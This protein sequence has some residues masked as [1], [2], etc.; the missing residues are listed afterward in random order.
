M[1]ETGGQINKLNRFV[2][3]NNDFIRSYLAGLKLVELDSA[4]R[5]LI[6]KDL[7]NLRNLIRVLC[8][9]HQLI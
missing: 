4:G 7:L 2:K 8:S 6:P 5:I 3:K 1:A 9:H